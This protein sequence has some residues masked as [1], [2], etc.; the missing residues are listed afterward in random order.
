M[1]LKKVS[2]LIS[3]FNKGDYIQE[4]LDSCIKQSYK[5]KE[6]IVYDNFSNDNS[7]EIIKKYKSVI[8]FRK[9]KI[10]KYPSCNQTDLIISAFKKSSG[11]IICLLDSDDFFF[12]N[13]LKIVVNYFNA[14]PSKNILYDTPIL[15]KGYAN[16]VFTIKNKFHYFTIW[17]T[18]FPT[19][20]ISFRRTFFIKNIKYFIKNKYPLLE[21]DFRLVVFDFLINNQYNYLDKHLTAYR[22]VKDGIMSNYKKLSKNW[23]KKRHQGFKYLRD[24]CFS[25]NL[26]FKK[27]L[28]FYIT[29]LLNYIF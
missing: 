4:C 28:D 17:P 13:K 18:I 20:T 16:K 8:F 29:R 5:N 7:K 15:K 19:S 2:I 9:K 12:K 1:K 14:N 10:S 23:W 22:I 26:A 25:H 11:D 3:N 27:G 6:I 21:I 24:L